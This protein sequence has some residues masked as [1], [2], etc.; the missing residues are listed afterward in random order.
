MHEETTKS[1]HYDIT[2]YF[3]IIKRKCWHLYC[4]HLTS[5]KLRLDQTIENT[6]LENI[7][8]WSVDRADAFSIFLYICNLYKSNCL[9][10]FLNTKCICTE[11]ESVF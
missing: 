1:I 11:T 10:S 7:L 5:A 3:N 9:Y 8:H 2:I 6:E 4:A